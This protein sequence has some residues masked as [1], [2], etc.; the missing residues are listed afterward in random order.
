M[1]FYAKNV[2][3]AKFKNALR[4]WCAK[5]EKD[6]RFVKG[7]LDASFA[8]QGQLLCNHKYARNHQ[9]NADEAFERQ[10]LVE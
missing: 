4:D 8:F 6:F 5:I 3:V 1:K 7:R 9:H 10:R 2:C